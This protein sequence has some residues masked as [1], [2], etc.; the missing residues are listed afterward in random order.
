[1]KKIYKV[2]Q[3][4]NTGFDTFDSFVCCALSFDD[5]M[6]MTPTGSTL[7]TDV[8]ETWTDDLAAINVVEI[9]TANED[10]EIGVILG[11]YNAA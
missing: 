9:G 1:M 4:V 7:S 2:E 3:S 8:T 6:N 10:T 11:S 5:A